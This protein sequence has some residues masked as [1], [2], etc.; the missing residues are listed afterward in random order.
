MGKAGVD[1]RNIVFETGSGHQ[2][3]YKPEPVWIGPL[4]E[5]ALSD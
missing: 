4:A 2:L 3:F 5:F 1:F